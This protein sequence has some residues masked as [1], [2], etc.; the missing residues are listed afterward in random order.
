MIAKSRSL[1]LNIST[2]WSNQPLHL[3]PSPKPILKFPYDTSIVYCPVT[4]PSPQCGHLWRPGTLQ[5]HLLCRAIS[6][7]V[8][9]YQ[10][11]PHSTY[12]AVNHVLFHGLSCTKLLFVSLRYFFICFYCIN[13]LNKHYIG[14]NFPVKQQSAL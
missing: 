7:V 1:A 11:S 6:E 13:N 14:T 9:F 12:L 10:C 8:C 2:I 4:M 3:L 5:A